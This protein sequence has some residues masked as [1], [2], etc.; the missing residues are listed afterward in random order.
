MGI[1]L[2]VNKFSTP[3]RAAL[4]TVR[5][6]QA[7][8]NIAINIKYLDLPA[9]EHMTPEFLKINPAHTVPAISDNGFNLWESRAILAYLCN[10]YS[11]ESSLYPKDPKTRALVDRS[12]NF[13]NTFMTAFREVLTAKHFSGVDPPEDKVTAFHNNLKV[14]DAL[15][16]RNKYLI[17]NHLTI[18]DFSLG[19]IIANFH[20]FDFS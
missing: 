4:M 8:V 12:L 1:D 10:Q 18:A 6:L 7:S 17:G 20:W 19:A 16:G 9:N 15:I 2:Y 3:S 14:L 13:D 5:Q 11:P